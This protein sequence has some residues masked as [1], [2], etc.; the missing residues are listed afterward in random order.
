[1]DQGAVLAGQVAALQ[2]SRLVS[3]RRHQW[4]PP[5]ARD[6]RQASQLSMEQAGPELPAGEAVMRVR[7]RWP[8]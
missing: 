8:S 5:S 6:W 4:D 3:N 2:D 1:V 7:P